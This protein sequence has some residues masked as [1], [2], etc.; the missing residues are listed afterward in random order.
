MQKGAFSMNTWVKLLLIAS[1]TVAAANEEQN[2]EKS[3]NE[4]D[5]MKTFPKKLLARRREV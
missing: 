3:G 2:T 4:E 1:I 5:K